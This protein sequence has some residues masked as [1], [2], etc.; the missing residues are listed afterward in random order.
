MKRL[1]CIAAVLV[2][3]QVGLFVLTHFSG[4][5]EDTRSDKGPL[6]TLNASEVNELLLEDGEGRKLLLKKEK[7]RWVLP[8]SAS[9]PADTAR[10][11]GLIERLAGLQRGWPEAVTAEAADR[12]KVAAGRFERKLSLRKDGTPLGVVYFGT[13]PGLRKIFLRVDDDPEI[14]SLALAQHELEVKAD[15]WIDTGVLHLKSEQV[16]RVEL[17]GLQLER[18][19]DG[20]QP[21]DLKPEEEVVKDR[22]DLLVKRLTGLSINSILGV[23][24]KPE[25]GLV[26]PALRYSLEMEGGTKIDYVFGQPPKAENKE[27]QLPAAESSFVLKVSD[28]QQLFR[29]DGWQVEEIRNATR[30]ALVRA[31]TQEQAGAPAASPAPQGQ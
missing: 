26:N 14:Q 30:A 20:L 10:I 18:Q 5:S 27:G 23:E 15:N 11:Q 9:F 4:S 2:L 31:R 8:E 29:V 12:F 16:T 19:K 1:T 25:Y 6:L 7:E 22:R 3:V 17:P 24:S 13:S 28:Q 21:V